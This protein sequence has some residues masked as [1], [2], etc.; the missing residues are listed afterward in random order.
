[1]G[2]R[3]IAVTMNK[4][5]ST[6]TT[7]AVHLA[8]ALALQGKNVLLI[9]CDPQSREGNVAKHLGITEEDLPKTLED[10]VINGDKEAIYQARPNLFILRGGYPLN[11]LRRDIDNRQLGGHLVLTEALAPLEAIFDYFIFDTPPS[12]DSLN[13]NALFCANEIIIPVN[14]EGVSV[15]TLNDYLLI[16]LHELQKYRPEPL[17]WGFALPT[18]Y[19]K[20]V[21]QSDELVTQLSTFFDSTLSLIP[22]LNQYS[23]TVLCSPI[24]INVRIS[25]AFGH[26]E[27]VFEY[28][29]KEF[30]ALNYMEFAKIVCPEA[31]PKQK[32]RSVSN[33]S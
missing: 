16:N 29:P 8:H 14:L 13:L 23:N 4:G 2:I 6:K 31:F 10:F 11:K 7:T 17:R 5:G 18:R 21:A 27:T 26:G 19:D 28:A 22:E 12:W 32:K 15:N 25:E 24:R 3:K 33:V 20:R 1:M 30:G 9:D